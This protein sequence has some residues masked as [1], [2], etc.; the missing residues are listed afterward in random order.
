MKI[1]KL[2]VTHTFQC[3]RVELFK[4]FLLLPL[5]S[6]GPFAPESWHFGSTTSLTQDI[7]NNMTP[8][9]M[10]IAVTVKLYNV[11]APNLHGK[12][13]LERAPL[14]FCKSFWCKWTWEG[15]GF[16]A[17]AMWLVYNGHAKRAAGHT[18]L[19]GDNIFF[20]CENIFFR[21]AKK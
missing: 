18:A 2:I 6:E 7:V 17:V 15:S 3:T 12:K 13:R 5:F 16:N 10:S 21:C 9:Q 14:M 1:R 8:W 11:C 4:H 19:P 20:R